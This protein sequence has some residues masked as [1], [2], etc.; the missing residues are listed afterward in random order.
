MSYLQRQDIHVSA[1]TWIFK[2]IEYVLP[3]T[4]MTIHQCKTITTSLHKDFLSRMGINK[5][6][7]TV[8]YHAPA[9]YQGLNS[10]DI[11]LTQH[12]ENIKMF[13]AHVNQKTQ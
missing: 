5:H 11:Q 6:L 1:F 9:R 12:I 10:M 4:S 13:L 7:P 3:A 2:T 8:Y